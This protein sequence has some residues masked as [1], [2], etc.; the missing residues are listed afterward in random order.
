MLIVAFIDA[1]PSRKT[2]KPDP[3]PAKGD[4]PCD[5]GPA[6]TSVAFKIAELP[7][8]LLVRIFKL[9]IQDAEDPRPVPRDEWFASDRAV[10]NNPRAALSLV[11]KSW[12]DIMYQCKLF[13]TT[14]DMTRI[15]RRRL[16]IANSGKLP[17][18]VKWDG[19]ILRGRESDPKFPVFLFRRLSR[20]NRLKSLKIVDDSSTLRDLEDVDLSCLKELDFEQPLNGYGSTLPTSPWL[21]ACHLTKICLRYACKPYS[22]GLA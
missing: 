18:D 9:Y 2:S 10:R 20:S 16:Y 15:K 3:T 13:W 22:V 11:C 8:E 19:T 12:K 14:I 7:T 4:A 6:V 5:A 21:N 1:M 17:L